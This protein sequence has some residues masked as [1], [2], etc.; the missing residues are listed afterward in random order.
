MAKIRVYE[1]SDH[2]IA[3]QMLR[4]L[5]VRGGVHALAYAKALE[6]LTGPT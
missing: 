6:E 5:F 4:Y 2:P 3:R 1:T